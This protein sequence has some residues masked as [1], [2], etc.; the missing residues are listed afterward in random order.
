MEV[1]TDVLAK[2]DKKNLEEG[3]L[4]GRDVKRKLSGGEGEEEFSGKCDE[5]KSMTF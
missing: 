4:V 2:R 3:T 1:N 5:M